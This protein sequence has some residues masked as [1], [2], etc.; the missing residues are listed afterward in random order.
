M[1]TGATCFLGAWLL[2]EIVVFL[3]AAHVA[4]VAKR[5]AVSAGVTKTYSSRRLAGGRMTPSL[6]V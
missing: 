4:V 1:R 2:F 3:L 6:T 5:L